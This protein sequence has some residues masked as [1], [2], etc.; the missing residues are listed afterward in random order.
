MAWTTPRTWTDGEVVTASIMNTHIR[1]NLLE[2][3]AAPTCRVYRSTSL[4]LTGT[5]TLVDMNAES[6]DTGGWHSTT[7]NPSRVTPTQQGLYLVQGGASF[8]TGAFD[9]EA[10]LYRNGTGGTAF[11]SIGGGI[12]PNGGLSLNL[13]L[14]AV[15][16]ANGTTDYFSLGVDT[17]TSATVNAGEFITWLS[18]TFLGTT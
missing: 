9:T 4:S 17:G 7:S 2:L 15:Y 14:A 12:Y 10:I 13:T 16:E 8:A 18:V 5:V 11:A 3:R 6:Y 1:D